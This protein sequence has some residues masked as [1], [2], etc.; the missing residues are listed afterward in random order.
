MA[1]AP[2]FTQTFFAVTDQGGIHTFSNSDGQFGNIPA[3]A[4]SPAFGY[5]T[6]IPTTFHGVIEMHPDHIEDSFGTTFPPA[7]APPPNFSGMSLGPTTIEGGRFSH[8]MFATTS[9]G[10]L[11]A[12]EINDNQEAVPAHVFYGGRS[13]VRLQFTDD[14]QVD[15]SLFLG[16]DSLVHQ[17]DWRLATWKKAHGI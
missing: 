11:Y 6:V 15:P 13:A 14:I 2:D 12:I 1:I 5:Q 16:I 10:W 4:S 3:P 9:D 8:V 7:F 17:R